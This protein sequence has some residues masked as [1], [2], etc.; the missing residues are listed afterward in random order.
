[1]STIQAQILALLKELQAK[2]DMAMLFITHDLSIVRK[3]ADRICVMNEGAIVEAGPTAEIFES[4][5]HEYTKHLLAAEPSGEKLP[6]DPRAPVVLQGND[7]RVW[8]PIKKGLLRRTAAYVK[9]VD[10]FSITIRE[11]QT[12]GIVGESGLRQ[13]NAR[14]GIAQAGA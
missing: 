3:M 13:D 6:A 10:G 2:L 1:M 7:L 14:Y 11:G 12:V 9:A 4:P 8:F 5:Q